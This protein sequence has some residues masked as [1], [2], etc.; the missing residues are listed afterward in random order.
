[1]AT[2]S[3]WD[4]LLQRPDRPSAAVEPQ[5][6]KVATVLHAI[7]VHQPVTTPELKQLC[8]LRSKQV[9]GLMCQPIRVG[10]VEFDGTYWRMV[11]GYV[12]PMLLRAAELLRAAGWTVEEPRT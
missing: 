11:P 9:W 3:P 10:Q 8:G 1:M 4:A 2:A 12:A 7:E 5:G 6:T